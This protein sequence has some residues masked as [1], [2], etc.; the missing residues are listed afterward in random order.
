MLRVLRERFPARRIL[1]PR[2]RV[3]CL[4][5][6]VPRSTFPRVGILVFPGA[7]TSAPGRDFE[8]ATAYPV[9][10]TACAQP[11]RSIGVPEPLGR[12][13]RYRPSSP[14]SAPTTNC[15]SASRSELDAR[16]PSSPSPPDEP[17]ID[18]DLRDHPATTERLM[19]R[20]TLVEKLRKFHVSRRQGPHPRWRTPTTALTLHR[21][22]PL[23]YGLEQNWMCGVRVAR[24][25]KQDDDGKHPAG[26]Q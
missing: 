13:P 22:T 21:R 25:H 15:R 5:E 24:C 12:L 23:R 18:G 26:G 6:S 20:T 2:R 9:L 17:V 3:R 7:A 19:R 1:A 8:A 16:G 4:E 14:A 10:T 11:A